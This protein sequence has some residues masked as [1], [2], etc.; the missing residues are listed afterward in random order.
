MRDQR[1]S[2]PWRLGARGRWWFD[3]ALTLGLLVLG[4]LG[5]LMAGQPLAAFDN[6]IVGPALTKIAA[7]LVRNLAQ[8]AAAS[9]PMMQLPVLK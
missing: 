3:A 8:S 2:R 4:F 6:P 1:D 9:P 7:S 5:H